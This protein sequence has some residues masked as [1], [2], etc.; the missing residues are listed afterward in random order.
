MF[1]LAASS[2]CRALLAST[3]EPF[4][5]TSGASI[6]L[7]SFMMRKRFDEIMSALKYTNKKAPMTFVNQFH[8][9]HQMIDSFNDHYALEYSPSWL[10]CIDESRNVWLNKF[11]PNF[12]SLPHKPHQF[13]NEY[14]LIANGDK[15]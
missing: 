2:S 8:K 13:G 9:V 6:Y 15:G 5:M 12:M 3:I 11:C 7:N 4:D 10:S 1:S 14:H